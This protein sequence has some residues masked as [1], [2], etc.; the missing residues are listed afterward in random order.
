MHMLVLKGFL[1]FRRLEL[2][3]NNGRFQCNNFMGFWNGDK[4]CLCISKILSI[5]TVAEELYL[6]NFCG[7]TVADDLAGPCVRQ[8]SVLRLGAPKLA[9]TTKKERMGLRS[10]WCPLLF[11]VTDGDPD[12]AHFLC[13]FHARSKRS[14]VWFITNNTRLTKLWYLWQEPPFAPEH[15]FQ[16]NGN[17]EGGGES[18]GGCAT[19]TWL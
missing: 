14:F 19:A 9:C 7:V 2:K 3:K 10:R 15:S 6:N 18:P 16:M 12:W 8:P 4:N 1:G 13:N 17:Q 5:H 11:P